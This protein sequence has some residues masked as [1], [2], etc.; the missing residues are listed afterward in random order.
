M[1]AVDHKVM[2]FRFAGDGLVDRRIKQLIALGRPQWLTQIGGVALA[3]AHI[4][5]ASA[6]NP[7]AIAGFA[8]IVRQRRDKT[9]TSASFLYTHVARRTSRAIVDVLERKPLGQ[10]C[11][12]NRERQIL[13]ETRFI[14]VAEWHDLNYGEIHASSVSP[15]D[16]TGNL[17][18]VYALQG[19]RINLDLMPVR[20]CCIDA[21]HDILK[22]APA[23]DGTKFGRVERV[24]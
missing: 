15:L 11:A 5:R 23:S 12:H 21:G 1:S 9:E 17:I 22:I 4:E 6:G 2:P 10:S 8:E 14:D 13:I 7:N 18:F 19:D 20:F 24:E 16:Q 3:E